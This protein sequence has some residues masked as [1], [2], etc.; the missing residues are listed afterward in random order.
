MKV[1]SVQDIKNLRGCLGLT[2]EEFAQLV[3]VTGATINR[4]E[5]NHNGPTR[6]A[7]VRLEEIE[8]EL[9]EKG[10]GHENGR[11][12]GDARAPAGEV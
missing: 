8:R 2:Q 12:P 11:D 9:N 10:V 5:N 7:R 4:W 6:L 3:G 1:W